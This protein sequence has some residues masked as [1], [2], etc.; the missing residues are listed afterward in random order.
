MVELKGKNNKDSMLLIKN[1]KIRTV[2]EAIQLSSDG[3]TKNPQKLGKSDIFE[4]PV[5]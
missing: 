3:L 1:K 2:D 5:V 4:M